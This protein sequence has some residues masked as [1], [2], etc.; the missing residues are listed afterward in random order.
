MNVLDA[1]G[2]TPMLRLRHFVA[3]WNMVMNLDR[4]DLK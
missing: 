3:A 4:F 2:K 1:I